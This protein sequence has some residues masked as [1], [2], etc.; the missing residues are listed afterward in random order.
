MRACE[1][2]DLPAVP[3]RA[4][5]GGL[6]ASWNGRLAVAVATCVPQVRTATEPVARPPAV[7]HPVDC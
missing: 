5:S 3:G 6:I 2:E 7:I 4:A 1:S